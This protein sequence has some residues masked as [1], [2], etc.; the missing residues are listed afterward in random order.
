MS[1]TKNPTSANASWS[2]PLGA[3]G[4]PRAIK[5]L[6]YDGLLF[7]GDPHITC[8]RPGRRVEE[9][10]LEVPLDKIQQSREIAQSKNLFMV[11]VGDMLDNPNKYKAGTLKVVEDRGRIITGFA[12]AMDFTACVTVPGNHDKHEVRLTPDCTL[13]QMRDLRLIDVIEPGGAYAIIEIDGQKVGLGGTPYGEPIPKDVRGVFGEDVDRCVWITHDMFI[14]DHKI[15]VLRDPPEIKGV[16][17]AV[18]GHDHECQKPRT[19]GQTEW[20][21]IGNITR[22]AVDT[23]E[24]VPAVWQWDPVGGMRQHVLRYNE[25]AFDL[26]GMQVEANVK[27]AHEGEKQREKSLFSQLL[28]ADAKGEMERSDSGDLI[29]EDVDLVLSDQH[30]ALTDR[31]KVSEPAR[32]TVRNLHKRAPERMKASP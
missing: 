4:L 7:V 11:F 28:V 12:R 17:L 13:A 2:P 1:T 32:L 20:H 23:R 22:M 3:D 29:E 24:H 26:L 31:P 25:A 15:P 8:V 19:I 10:F 18:N 16:D 5:R 27:A 6:K 9:D 14:F 30:R 21:N